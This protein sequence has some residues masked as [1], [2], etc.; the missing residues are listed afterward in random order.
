MMTRQSSTSISQWGV[1]IIMQSTLD[2]W[3]NSDRR[4]GSVNLYENWCP[5][6]GLETLGT[7]PV[8]TAMVG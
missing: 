7:L 4:K 8:A 6:N 3:G 5:T 1:T 2:S